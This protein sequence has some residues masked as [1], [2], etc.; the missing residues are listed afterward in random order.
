[1]MS[2]LEVLVDPFRNSCSK[3]MKIHEIVEENKMGFH[4]FG[5]H[6]V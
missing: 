1:M 3:V 6:D 4:L 5:L 2:F